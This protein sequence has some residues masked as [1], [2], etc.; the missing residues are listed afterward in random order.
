MS[1]KESFEWVNP[2][3]LPKERLLKV[4]CKTPQTT[5]HPRDPKYKKRVFKVEEL[6]QN[7]RSLIG[8]RVGYNHQGVIMDS[9]VVDS[10]F[11]L[12]ESQLEG[13][14]YVPLSIIRKVRDHLIEQASVEFQWRAEKETDE[15]T[16]F[17]GLHIFRIDLLEGKKAGDHSADVETLLEGIEP[18]ERQGLFL[19]EMVGSPVL[20]EPMDRFENWD[21]CMAW[22]KGEPSIKD[23]EAYCGSL[24]AKEKKKEESIE[25]P[26]KPAKPV[27]VVAP[28][29]EPATEPTVKELKESLKRV[30]DENKALKESRDK[31]VEDARKE[32]KTSLVE[33]VSD[34]IPQ[35][36]I[37]RQSSAGMVRLIQDVRRVLRE[38]AK[39]T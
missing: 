3:D 18:V 21:A 19:M 28:V 1:L 27:P 26:E 7:G 11:N 32:I 23:P 9:M 22:A 33:K 37:V 6:I 15:G 36:V 10:E 30:L 24:K 20:G 2:K 35:N 5:I 16:E 13:L 17:E 38:V 4:V 8:T 29:V 14:L 25:T 31:A 12:K 39:E 34:V